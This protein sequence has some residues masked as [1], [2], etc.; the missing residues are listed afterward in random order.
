MIEYSHIQ[1][2]IDAK[3]AAWRAYQDGP[4]TWSKLRAAREASEAVTAAKV[5]VRDAFA[6]ERGWRISAR[7]FTIDQLRTGHNVARR[8]DFD[9]HPRPIDHPEYFRLAQRPWRPVAILSHEYSPFTDVLALAAR[10]GL[11]AELLPESWYSPGCCSAVLYTS[12][13]ES[14]P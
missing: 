9:S 7:S 10:K 13:L 8:G 3:N 4:G 12:R 11:I 6:A 1:Q 2:L 14:R 5:A